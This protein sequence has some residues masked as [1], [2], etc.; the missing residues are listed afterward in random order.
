MVKKI[1]V[2]TNVLISA[3]GW[4]GYPRVLL[5]DILEGKYSMVISEKQILELRRVMDYSKFGFKTSQKKR[6]L[7]I[8]IKNSILIKSKSSGYW[9]I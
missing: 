3:L 9:C 5:R 6:Y 7:E 1:V 4:E 2:D 8:L